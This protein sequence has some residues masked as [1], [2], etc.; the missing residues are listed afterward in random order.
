MQ[1][2]AGNRTEPRTGRQGRCGFEFNSTHGAS[3]LMATYAV[4]D[5]Q[6]C[7][8]EFVDL[9]SAVS[10]DPARDRLWL[11]GDLVN[12]GPD[13]LKVME[14]VMSLDG[15][16]ITVLGNHDLH[17]LAIHYGGHS[18][19]ASD[20]FHDLL[21]APDVDGVADWLR[22]QRFFHADASLGYAMAHAGIPPGWSMQQ[23]E[24]CS[25]ELMTVL[26]GKDYVTYFR[27]MYGNIPDRLSEGLAG[28]D[29][30][31]ILTNCFTR[32][33]LIDREGRLNF[34]HKGAL[35]EA[36]AGW[37]PWYELITD[38]LEDLRLLFGHWAALEGG[39]GRADIVALDTGC[40]WGR[41]L[42]ALCLE[43][44]EVTSVPAAVPRDAAN[45][46]QSRGRI[47]EPGSG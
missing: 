43:T 5:I 40:V 32:M 45:A 26:R 30:W 41:D 35:A 28:M 19:V 38:E 12:R 1:T 15:R 44:G 10:F 17:F 25:R 33:R 46:P 9:L 6:G 16:T 27:E 7:Y 37:F 21:A 18:P 13:S 47:P 2:G 22:G 23:A 24:A 3:V 42:T 34:T 31:R 4:G 8:T 29:R 39:T 20:T 11:L 36:P 14:L